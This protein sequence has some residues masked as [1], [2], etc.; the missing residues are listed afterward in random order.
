MVYNARTFLL[1]TQKRQVPGYF[2]TERQQSSAHSGEDSTQSHTRRSREQSTSGMRQQT[3]FEEVLTDEGANKGSRATPPSAHSEEVPSGKPG[4]YENKGS[5][6]LGRGARDNM[7]NMGIENGG[8]FRISV[9]TDDGLYLA[10]DTVNHSLY[11]NISRL[12]KEIY[13][14]HKK[15]EESDIVAFT[16]K[17]AVLN[18]TKH[19]AGGDLI[20]L[21]RGG[22]EGMKN[23]VEVAEGEETYA[24]DDVMQGRRRFQ[25]GGNRRFTQQNSEHYDSLTESS[26]S[27]DANES[28]ASTEDQPEFEEDDDGDGFDFEEDISLNF[29]DNFDDDGGKS[30]G[31]VDAFNAELMRGGS[32]PSDSF[33]SLTDISGSASFMSGSMMSDMQSRRPQDGTVAGGFGGRG[34]GGGEEDSGVRVTRE[35]VKELVQRGEQRASELTMDRLRKSNTLVSR[36]RREEKRLSDSSNLLPRPQA[37]MENTT[38]YKQKCAKEQD[39][40]LVRC[41]AR[42]Q[43][44]ARKKLGR[45]K[46]LPT[47]GSK[48]ISSQTGGHF[49]HNRDVIAIAPAESTS[50]HRLS[51]A[52][53]T[54]TLTPADLTKSLIQSHSQVLEKYRD[55]NRKYWRKLQREMRRFK[56][57]APPEVTQG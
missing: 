5:R 45:G 31:S 28:E 39:D 6:S 7:A 25:G 22:K 49:R 55:S 54:P 26:S 41:L 29:E 46:K 30:S 24:E 52:L 48:T 51:G 1:Q 33:G 42:K 38:E 19:K 2:D 50:S 18:A 32:T 53:S 14:G 34:V 13:R 16:D 56:S 4:L 44:R 40:P 20:E 47:L 27:D 43:R 17:D 3:S 10:G 57:T 11:N 23:I 37:K 21:F 15:K 35:E 36:L 12:R 9:D 8:C